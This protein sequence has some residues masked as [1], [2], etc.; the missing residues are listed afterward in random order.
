MFTN[1]YLVLYAPEVYKLCLENLQGHPRRL[2]I[3][4]PLQSYQLKAAE[5]QLFE[6]PS[7]LT[8]NHTRRKCTWVL[9]SLNHVSLSVNKD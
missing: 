6:K 2:K 1:T 8:N 9:H 3:T 7:R 4:Y 5:K